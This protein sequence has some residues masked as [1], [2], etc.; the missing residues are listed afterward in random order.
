MARPLQTEEEGPPTKKELIPRLIH[1]FTF[2]PYDRHGQ[3]GFHRLYARPTSLLDLGHGPGL[4]SNTPGG[5]Q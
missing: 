4:R 3:E 1:T 5:F 2:P